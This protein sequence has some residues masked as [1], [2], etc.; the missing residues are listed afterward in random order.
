MYRS[1]W[2]LSLENL[3]I[4]Y[5]KIDN[6]DPVSALQH[7]AHAKQILEVLYEE[8]PVFKDSSKQLE[9]L[10]A[11]RVRVLRESGSG[12]EWL[13]C[14]Q[15]HRELLLRVAKRFNDNS[16]ISK[17][18]QFEWWVGTELLKLRRPEEGL[19]WIAD[20]CQHLRQFLI[21]CNGTPKDQLR[22][23]LAVMRQ[24]ISELNDAGLTLEATKF[25]QDVSEI[26]LLLKNPRDR[27]EYYAGVLGK[28]SEAAEQY[29][30]AFRENPDD[31]ESAQKA[32]VLL[33]LDGDLAGHEAICRQML[34]RFATSDDADATWH[35][36]LTCLISSHP[37]VDRNDLSQL[38]DVVLEQRWSEAGQGR[39]PGADPTGYWEIKASDHFE[40][41]KIRGLAAYRTGNW[42]GALKWCAESC[43]LISPYDDDG[44]RHKAQ[45]LLVEG[46]ALQQSGKPSQ[47]NTAFDDAV[48]RMQQS[49]VLR[50]QRSDSDADGGVTVQRGWLTWVYC[51]LLR[52]EAQTLIQSSTKRNESQA[53]DGLVEP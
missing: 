6:P 41:K 3:G 31:H 47:A 51:E 2:A 40:E 22:V 10:R 26:V 39:T 38:A 21:G 7:F 44:P 23:L 30:A 13:L 43:E 25:A 28:Y 53:T 29:Q 50:D 52:R 1:D 20:S 16:R 45:N 15:E 4:S 42:D 35:T 14:A 5:L 36:L 33:L 18:V 32:A 34:E 27:G 11:L 19:T 8:F 12:D 17:A 49:A 46:M 48:L 24:S 37:V 9:N